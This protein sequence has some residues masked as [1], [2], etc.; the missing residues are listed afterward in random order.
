MPVV[1]LI[2]CLSGSIVKTR[3]HRA[4]RVSTRVNATTFGLFNELHDCRRCDATLLL[5]GNIRQYR[6][7][8]IRRCTVNMLNQADSVY[9]TDGMSVEVCQ[10]CVRFWQLQ[11]HKCD[12]LVN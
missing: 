8:S 10:K 4:R 5:S 2:A 12:F 1:L 11:R 6:F 7:V 3:S 9:G